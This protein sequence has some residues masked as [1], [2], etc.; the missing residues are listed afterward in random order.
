MNLPVLDEHLGGQAPASCFARV[1]FRNAETVD[2]FL[3]INASPPYS[4]L[5]QALFLR[6]R[7][8]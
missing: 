6:N 8:M 3:E 2:D 1:A 5:Y 7:V 4:S